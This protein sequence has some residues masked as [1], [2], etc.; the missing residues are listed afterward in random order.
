MRRLA[1]LTLLV[2]LSL[3]AVASG[4]MLDHAPE[5]L[6]SPSAPLSSVVNAGGDEASWELVATIPTGNPHSDLDFFTFGQDP[7]A[8]VRSLGVGPNR[9]GQNI[10]QLTQGGVVEPRYVSGH[11]SAACPGVF[12]SATGLQHDVEATPKG[13]AFQQQ[14]NLHIARGDA[15][16]LLDSTDGTGRCHDNGSAFGAS[17]APSGGIE[18]IDVTNVNEPKEIGLISHIGNAH[19]V[20]VDPNRPHI[21][22]DIPQDGVTV[23]PDGKRS[24]EVNCPSSDP[25]APAAGTPSTSNALDGFELIDLSSCMNFP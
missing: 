15:Q 16:L 24:N 18:I 5:G 21:A 22:F 17:G 23:C 3:A 14:P 6:N 8:S 7:Y 9:G 4:H 13:N 12:T 19:T 10:V 11:P 2:V 1:P 20:N 25:T